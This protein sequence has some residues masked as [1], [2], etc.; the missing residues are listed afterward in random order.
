MHG[1]GFGS[2]EMIEAKQIGIHQVG[3]AGMLCLR[4]RSEVGDK[5][6]KRVM[7][8]LV[9][10]LCLLV[11]KPQPLKSCLANLCQ[12]FLHGSGPFTDKRQWPTVQKESVHPCGGNCLKK[13]DT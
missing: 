7:A 8:S 3:E 1:S 11:F 5:E 2:L 4:M 9:Q 10:Y 12:I 6:R 13:S